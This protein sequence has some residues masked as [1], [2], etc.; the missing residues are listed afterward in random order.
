MMCFNMTLA[1]T[2]DRLVIMITLL[3]LTAD[4]LDAAVPLS[5]MPLNHTE[6]LPKITRD[7]IIYY[8]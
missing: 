5:G 2:P 7:R 8:V 1:G 4:Y 3:V 6:R